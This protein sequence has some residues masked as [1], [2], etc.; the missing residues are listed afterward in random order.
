MVNGVPT[1]NFR[2]VAAETVGGDLALAGSN[3]MVPLLPS[4][5][6]F[7]HGKDEADRAE[8]GSIGYFVVDGITNYGFFA[9]TT[10]YFNKA[11]HEYNENEFIN[12][13]SAGSFD[14]CYLCVQKCCPNPPCSC[15]GQCPAEKIQAKQGEIKYSIAAAAH[16]VLPND[17]QGVLH[18][19]E[20]YIED[21]GTGNPKKLSGSF[22]VYQGID[23]TDM[24]ADWI[25]LKG[26]DGRTT[27]YADMQ[28]CNIRDL[29]TCTLY[30]VQAMTVGADDWEGMS[31]DFPQTFNTGTWQ[32]TTNN[33]LKNLYTATPDQTK[34]AKI[35]AV[36]PDA[37]T[38]AAFSATGRKV[39]LLR[40]TFSAEDI[41]ASWPC[42]SAWA[43]FQ[44]QCRERGGTYMVYDPTVTNGNSITQCGPTEAVQQSQ[45]ALMNTLSADCKAAMGSAWGS[46]PNC[47]S[48]ASSC[49]WTLSQGTT[50]QTSGAQCIPS[51]CDNAADVQALAKANAVSESRKMCLAKERGQMGQ[52]EKATMS[53]QCQGASAEV[54]VTGDAAS[55]GIVTSGAKSTAAAFWAAVLVALPAAFGF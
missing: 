37:A 27:K 8:V 38:L 49:P 43:A 46:A 31:F 16:D 25:S 2:W 29:S 20:K 45:Q 23:F 44:G 55:N 7:V 4:T 21:K 36:K 28:E 35:E 33:A 1:E 3:N 10:S 19:W 32:G 41:T 47:A 15:N 18:G 24:K 50:V 40:Y 51:V 52:T 48:G 26:T 54:E 30:S 17:G 9:S 53:Y 22:Y 14:S 13:M 5:I 42:Q 34:I 11:D 39:F 6:P 12:G